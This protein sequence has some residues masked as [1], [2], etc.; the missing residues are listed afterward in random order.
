MDSFDSKCFILKN[1]IQTQTSLSHT[2]YGCNWTTAK[3]KKSIKN[4]IKKYKCTVQHCE[5]KELSWFLITGTRKIT[6]VTQLFKKFNKGQYFTKTMF[7]DTD[8]S[9]K[10]RMEAILKEK[11]RNTSKI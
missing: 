9:I 4:I 8:M 5:L 10:K 6:Q 1:R 2:I 3:N 7:E 11:E